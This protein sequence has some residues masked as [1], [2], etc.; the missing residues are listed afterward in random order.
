MKSVISPKYLIYTEFHVNQQD[1]KYIFHL[2]GADMPTALDSP[3]F[4]QRNRQSILLCIA[5]K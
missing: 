4:L 5:S 1:K 3:E 2:K